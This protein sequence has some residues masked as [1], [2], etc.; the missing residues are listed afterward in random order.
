MLAGKQLLLED[1]PFPIED[2]QSHYENGFLIYRKGIVIENNKP[3][4]V[5]C[6]N[7]ESHLFSSYP[8]AR[9][10]E[11]CIYCRKCIMMGRVS[12]CS[13]LIGWTGPEPTP[14]GKVESEPKEEVKQQQKREIEQILFS[15]R[16]DRELDEDDMKAHHS[17]LSLTESTSKV[18]HN[19]IPC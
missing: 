8:C 18:P 6:G 17:S 5:R 12:A 7:E 3:R 19:Q 13:P 16:G 10:G 9:C 2:I 1:L 15:I 4:C 11:S 14:G